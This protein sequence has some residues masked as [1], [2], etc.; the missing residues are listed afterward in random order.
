MYKR[1]FIELDT[2]IFIN[3]RIINVIIKSLVYCMLVFSLIY[4]FEQQRRENV[5]FLKCQSSDIIY[6][7]KLLQYQKYWKKF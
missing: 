4:V 1:P 6:N 5:E 7:I 2:D 3:K